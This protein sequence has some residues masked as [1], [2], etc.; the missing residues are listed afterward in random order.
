MAKWAKRLAIFM[1]LLVWLFIMITPTLAV[2]LARNGQIQLGSAEGPHT[3]IF[4][5]QEAKKEGMA[6]ER[7]R[8]VRPPDGAEETAACLRTTVRYWMWTGS[9]EDQNTAYC[10]CTDSAT[11]AVIDMVPSACTV[12]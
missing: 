1:L 5:L 9:T 8:E 12:P 3:R 4:M 2:V 11:G 6:I 7:A 10:S